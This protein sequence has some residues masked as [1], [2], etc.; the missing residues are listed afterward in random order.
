MDATQHTDVRLRKPD[1]TQYS[2]QP[3]CLEELLPPQHPA[4]VIWAVVQTLDL[5]D[6]Y[7]AIRARE[8]CV[9]RDAT[10][11]QLLVALWLYATT[12]AVGSARELA[13]LCQDHRAFRWLCGSVSVNHH[14]LSDFRVGHAD[15]LDKL[16]SQVLA[17]LIEKQLVS[18]RRIVQDG[19][20]IRASVG[21]G[22]MRR[23]KSLARLHDEAA[24]HVKDLRALLDDP[25]RCADLSAR[26]K[27][28]RLRGAQDRQRRLAEA[29]EE[30]PRL[31][32]ELAE[33][34]RRESRKTF[35]QTEDIRVSHT[36]AQTR[37]MKM[38]DG[39]YHPAHNV[40][41][42]ADPKSRAIVGVD[43]SNRGQDSSL[44]EPMRRQ[45]EQRTGQKVQE[46]VTDAGYVNLEQI[47]RAG[48]DGVTMYVALR[49]SKGKTDPYKPKRKDTPHVRA[50]RARMAG[51]EA[52]AKLKERSSTIETINADG[53]AHR[54]LGRVL[55]RGLS[56]VKCHALWFALSY[57]LLHFGSVF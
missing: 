53:K 36:D 33:S 50:W 17:K 16:F 46:H 41:L 20:R 52:K 51:E 45:V 27:A 24:A 34:A 22:S 4:R 23:S 7:A 31:G 57:N 47:E 26:Q 18:V 54:G 19:T 37:V 56:N 9:G 8:G 28:A 11:P 21:R 32:E 38:G 25:A 49:K 30:I 2:F 6:F 48:S 55:V 39:S 40:Q 42:A 35:K 14:T 44:S 10:D 3:Q 1:R 12:R 29:L 13:R 15:A 43:V 5:S